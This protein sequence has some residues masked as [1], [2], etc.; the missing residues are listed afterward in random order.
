MGSLRATGAVA[1]KLGPNN[2][3]SSCSIQDG[4]RMCLRGDTSLP[5]RRHFQLGGTSKSTVQDQ[6]WCLCAKR[7]FLMLLFDQGNPRRRLADAGSEARVE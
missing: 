5:W 3:D 4:M 7:G 1:D 2:R 6:G